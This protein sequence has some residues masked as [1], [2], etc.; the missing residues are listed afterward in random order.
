MVTTSLLDSV[1]PKS[2]A[3]GVLAGER[4][5]QMDGLNGQADG[6]PWL[7]SSIHSRRVA[8]RREAVGARAE[9]ALRPEKTRQASGGS[10]LEGAEGEYR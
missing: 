3:T 2:L 10:G 6:S 9:E 4:A 1:V 7:E 8:L 5:D